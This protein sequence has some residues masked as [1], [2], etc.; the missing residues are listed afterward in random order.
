MKPQRILAFLLALGVIALGM[1][2]LF[3]KDGIIVG[4]NIRLVFHI[5]AL[6]GNADSVNQQRIDSIINEHIEIETD[7][8]TV[9][10]P[11][12]DTLPAERIDT[13][14][15]KPEPAQTKKAKSRQPIEFARNDA[16]R[17]QTL[18]KTLANSDNR[19]I[20]ILHYG[21]SQIEG[22][23]IT[24]YLRNL[25]QRKYGGSGPGLMSA[26]PPIAQSSA[27][28]HSASGNW[29]VYSI[30]S[31][32]D[33][34]IHH[35]KFGIM[36]SLA[37]FTPTSAW[38]EFSPSGQ[39]Y[40]SVQNFTQCNVYYGQNEESFTVK[41]YVDNQL[42]W[43]EEFDPTTDTKRFQWNFEQA[44]K[45]FR[46]EIESEKKLDLYAITLDSPTGVIVDNLP[47]RGSKGTEFVK[48]DLAQMKQMGRYLPVSLI[49]YE[50]GVNAVTNN[51]KNYKYY[52]QNLRKQLQYLKKVWPKAEILVVGVSDMSEK[53][54]NGY[55]TR[56]SVTKVTEAQRNAAF[57][58][59]CAFWNLYE[60]MG[61]YNS[62]PVWVGNHLAQKDYTHF[63]REGGHRVAQ[64]LYDAITEELD[65]SMQ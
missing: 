57:A 45:H 13:A 46:I 47:F 42:K 9:D 61:G 4:D 39:A 63:N 40:K 27:I 36:G 59:G 49:I 17:F 58:E 43:F 26:M 38:I 32:K 52:E 2:L 19:Q 60:A 12:A 35:N 18:A 20:R 6:S 10:T 22:D 64:M 41:G 56:A 29:K 48:L 65:A 62:M 21:D 50:F 55:V 30:Y 31:K 11:V 53:G 1:A 51:S 16:E 54:A 15:A 28:N 7:S 24:G 44:P 37:Q 34:S 3:P 5:D 8:T 33:T 23:R 25:L 14:V